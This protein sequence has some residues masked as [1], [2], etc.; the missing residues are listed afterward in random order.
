MNKRWMLRRCKVNTNELSRRTGVSE[1]LLSVLANRGIT[2]EKGIKDFM[3]PTLDK[4]YDPIL[5]KDMDK[6]TDII[7]K[8]IKN[9]DK[10]AVYGDY[11]ADGITSTFILYSALLKCGADVKYHIPDRIKEGYGINIISLEKLKLEGYNTI[12]TCDNGISAVDQIKR[13]KEIGMTV[14]VTDHHD[15]PF[16][17]ESEKDRTFILPCA[18]AI[19]NPKQ[20][21]CKYPFKMLC[22]AGVAFKF[23][24]A[25]YRKMGIDETKAYK[26]IEYASIGTICDIVDL[27]DENRII[28]KMG[29]DLLNRTE[30]LGIKALI[31]ENSLEIGNITAY[32]IGFVIGPCINAAGRLES[33]EIALK[34]LM[35]EDALGAE[36]LAKKL[37]NLNIERQD[38]TLKSLEEIVNIVEESSLKNDKVLVVYKEDVHESIA[39][40]VAGRLKERYNL[41]SI[42]LTKGETM[43]KGSARSIEEYNMYEE[44]TKCSDLMENFGGHKMAAGM[45]LKEENIEKLRKELNFNCTLSEEDIIPKI[46]IDKRLPLESVSFKFIKDIKSLEPFGKGNSSPVFAEKNIEIFKVYFMGK[47]KNIIKLFC[48]LKNGMEKIDAISFD[49]GEKFKQI[50]EE[51]YGTNELNNVLTNKFKHIFMDFI[52]SPSINKYN[53]N[54]KIQLIVKDFRLSKTVN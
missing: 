54:T 52:F 38:M 49:G 14:V 24:Q 18:D 27:V 22:G 40:I 36:A 39:G 17:G 37:R 16:L 43:A 35:S 28:A 46:R 30:N 13:A 12:I 3:N 15:I 11:D 26:F 44:L 8:A 45:S 50:I 53:G 47:D 6:G 48:R 41:P 9:H 25:L 2:G 33:A 10:I 1:V 19:I 29:I 20:K 34:L 7:C 21:D 32:H 23:A 42:V 5:M 51:K 4:L 31:E